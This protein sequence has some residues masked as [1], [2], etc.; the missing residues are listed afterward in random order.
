MGLALVSLAAACTSQTGILPSSN[1][2]PVDTRESSS[3]GPARYSATVIVSDAR[4]VDWIATGD[5]QL[6]LA[7]NVLGARLANTQS[8]VTAVPLTGGDPVALAGTEAL[9][10]G[11]TGI[12]ASGDVVYFT[13]VGGPNLRDGGVFRYASGRSVAVLDG[14]NAPAGIAV[15]STDEMFIAETYTG[16]VLRVRGATINTYAGRG[17]CADR[18]PPI[19][20]AATDAALCSLELLAMTATGDLYISGHGQAWIAKV[21]PTETLSVFVTDFGPSSLAI[22]TKGELLAA[23]GSQLVH[24]DAAGTPTVIA[25]D[26]GLIRSISV[27][28]DGSIYVL[29]SNGSGGMERVTRLRAI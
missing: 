27:S 29:H 17:A 12:A 6:F 19:A 16:Q 8:K 21:D 20:G 7:M 13:R 2:A 28:R 9:G 4:W 11:I 23:R 26:L 24:F 5:T 14:R 22:D 15:S 18:N 3:P 1:P 10:A 25:D